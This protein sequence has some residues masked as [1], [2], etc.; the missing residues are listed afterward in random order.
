MDYK[1]TFSVP[2]AMRPMGAVYAKRKARKAQ[3]EDVHTVE[4]TL[5]LMIELCLHPKN[6]TLSP[7]NDRTYSLPNDRTLSLPNDRTYF[8]PND[9]TLS[10]PNDRTL[11]LPNDREPYIIKKNRSV[12]AIT[13]LEPALSRTT[14]LYGI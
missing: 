10:L 7:P 12:S 14:V 2:G 9:R 6:K 13:G 5:Y 3:Q 11:S 8:L 4:L 1:C